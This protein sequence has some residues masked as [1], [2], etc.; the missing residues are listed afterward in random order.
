MSSCCVYKSLRR[1]DTYVYLA[2]RDDFDVL[3]S[4]LRGGLLPLAFV[5]ELDL[6]TPRRLGSEDFAVVRANV[7]QSGFH[8]QLPPPAFAEF[9]K[10]IDCG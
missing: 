10:T 8:L 6:T 7:Q 9:G 5:L 4:A 3:P 2:R 1:V